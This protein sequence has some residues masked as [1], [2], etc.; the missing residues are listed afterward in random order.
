MPKPAEWDSVYFGEYGWSPAYRY[1]H[2][3]RFAGEEWQGTNEPNAESPVKFQLA[4]S[5]YTA[6]SGGFDCSIDEGFR[7]GLPQPKIVDHF[8]L[9]WHGEYA[10]FLDGDGKLAVFDPTAKEPGPDATLMRED[11]LKKYLDECNLDLCWVVVGEKNIIGG[12]AVAVYHGRL[13]IS[14]AYRLTEDGPNGFINAI[15]EFPQNSSDDS[16]EPDDDGEANHLADP[17]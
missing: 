9:R 15:P 3:E 17:G 11:L 6:G 13:K 8:G 10:D 4:S 5:R 16:E 2:N 14:G 1:F 12:D 7:L